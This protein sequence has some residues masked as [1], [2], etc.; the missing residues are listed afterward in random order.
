MLIRVDEDW[1]L[2][3]PDAWCMITN[4]MEQGRLDSHE[5]AC[6]AINSRI[7]CDFTAT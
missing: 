5:F 4:P 7:L 6:R 3:E 1:T 2:C